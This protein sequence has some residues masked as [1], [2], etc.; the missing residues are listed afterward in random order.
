M[1][2]IVG[3]AGE[4]GY[5]VAEALCNEGHDVAVIEKEAEACERADNLDALVVK[6]NAASPKAL[7]EAGVDKADMFIGVT[8]SD[9]INMLGCA[10]AKTKGCRTISRINALDYINEPV[11]TGYRDVGIDVAVCPDLVAAIKVA[12]MLL[13]PSMLDADIFA[14]GRVQV[15]ESTIEKESPVAGKMIKDIEF[16][17]ACNI[18][19]VFRNADVIIP[20]GDDILLPNDRIVAVLGEPNLIPKMEEIVGSQKQVMKK[21][22]VERVI[23]VGASRIGV[24]LARLLEESVNV[25]LIEPAK[26]MCEAASEVLSKTT[27]IHGSETDKDVLV[28]EGVA[29]VDAF[30]AANPSDES[31]MLSCLLAKEYGAKKIIALI[32]RPELKSVLEPVAM[33]VNPHL[34]T[35]SSVLQYARKSDL[36][37]FKMLK[38]GEAQVL[39]FKVTNK[40][41]IVSKKLKKAGF[42][43][44][45]IVGA[46]VRD[47][48]VI[49]PSG[50]DEIMAGDKLIVFARTEGISR[51][52]RLF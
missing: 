50:E 22:A 15:L 29:G 52:E 33:T 2:V 37:S 30:I 11:T 39:E 6:G 47:D 28:E 16:P 5:H 8:G 51:L 48:I 4:V 27:V 45:S 34:V 23:I 12:R 43:S 18:V 10:I 20:H 26:R 41:K 31:N 38:E 19:A 46:I 32:N 44:N 25:T 36:L 14:K 40:S 13:V 1:Y 24:H 42:P 35:I 9:E 3:G 49:I 17:E 7:S 21:D